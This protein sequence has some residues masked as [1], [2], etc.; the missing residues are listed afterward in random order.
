MRFELRGQRVVYI[1][2]K[3][4]AHATLF[5]PAGYRSLY[6]DGHS[7]FDDTVRRYA[8][9]FD[10]LN[11]LL[12]GEYVTFATADREVTGVRRGDVISV[13]PQ[14]IPVN[15]SVAGKPLSLIRRS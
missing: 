10:L 4:G 8:W 7:H 3:P 14:A 5:D 1:D 11:P 15:R 2:N 9:A 12:E 13:I 6:N